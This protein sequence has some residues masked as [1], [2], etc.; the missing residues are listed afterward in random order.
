MLFLSS[1]SMMHVAYSTAFVTKTER[2]SYSCLTADTC[3]YSDVLSL[4]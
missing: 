2:Y 4:C 3:T 1:Y